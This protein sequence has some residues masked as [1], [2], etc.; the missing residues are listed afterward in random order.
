[1]RVTVTRMFST[2]KYHV[3]KKWRT[4]E[5]SFDNYMTKKHF[6][7]DDFRSSFGLFQDKFIHE[8]LSMLLTDV[9]SRTWQARSDH[10]NHCW[11]FSVL[12]IRQIFILL[13]PGKCATFSQLIHRETCS[14]LNWTKKN[15]ENKTMMWHTS[16]VTITLWW[17]RKTFVTTQRTINKPFLVCNRTRR[18]LLEP[19]EIRIKT[20]SWM[21]C[22]ENDQIQIDIKYVEFRYN[23]LKLNAFNSIFLQIAMRF[24]IFG[25]S[26][27]LLI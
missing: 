8:H 25:Q 12:S 9:P 1:M 11:I 3:S 10:T 16:L 15:I 17:L 19:S 5:N 22:L 18:V 4:F 6:D 7:V 2:Y 23:Y 13:D 26:L 21:T 14:W 20:C 27:E 24:P